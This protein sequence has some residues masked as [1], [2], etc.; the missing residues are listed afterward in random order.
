MKFRT[1]LLDLLLFYTLYILLFSLIESIS[2]PYSEFILYPLA[3]A[4]LISVLFSC[5]ES[6]PRFE[7]EQ[8]F[9]RALER[10]LSVLT[11]STIFAFLSYL[12]ILVPFYL[13]V[14]DA[15]FQLLY[16]GSFY[17]IIRTSL[18]PLCFYENKQIIDA[19]KNSG[20]LF[21]KLLAVYS[22]LL[23]LA[24]TILF[25]FTLPAAALV[26]RSLNRRVNHNI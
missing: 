24:D 1:Y 3:I 20:P 7:A 17:L 26:V 22:T 15:K 23:L 2:F 14:I 6:F 4:L 19:W 10:Y 18:I 25:I 5:A 13:S 21:W 12:L 16:L 9:D 11:G 8:I